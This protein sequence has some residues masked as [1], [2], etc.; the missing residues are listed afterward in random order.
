MKVEDTLNSLP[1]KEGIAN[2]VSGKTRDSG[3]DILSALGIFGSGR[4]LALL[5]TP[6]PGEELRHD[7]AEK[8]GSPEAPQRG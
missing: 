3:G 4:F 6:K 5:F 1:S 7:V 2:A 8:L